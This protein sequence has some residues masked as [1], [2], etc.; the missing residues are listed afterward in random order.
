[1][2]FYYAQKHKVEVNQANIICSVLG[3]RSPEL[4]NVDVLRA[5]GGGALTSDALDVAKADEYKGTRYHTEHDLPSTVVPG[6]NLLFLTVAAAYAVNVGVYDLWTG[7][8]LADY[9]GYPDCRPEFYGAAQLAIR[10]ALADNKFSIITPLV[11][12]SK[13]QTFA[14]ADRR[15]Y[16][17]LIVRY[18]HTCYMGTR[19]KHEWG[20]GCGECPACVTREQGWV[21]FKQAELDSL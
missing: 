3:V 17:D 6:R 19:H 20:Y 18:T 1:V 8:C 7:G 21:E 5:L 13:A 16:L 2:S 12:V 9:D 11:G 15:G 10:E 14:M 4:F